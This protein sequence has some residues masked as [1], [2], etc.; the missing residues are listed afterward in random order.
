[1]IYFITIPLMIIVLFISSKYINIKNFYVR[2]TVSLILAFIAIFFFNENEIIKIDFINEI[3]NSILLGMAFGI[4]SK[5]KN[6]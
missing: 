2:L 5:K 1:M 3:I 6:K 4:V